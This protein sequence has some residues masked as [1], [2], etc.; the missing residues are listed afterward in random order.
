MP[1]VARTPASSSSERSASVLLIA[2]DRAERARLGHAPGVQDRL[3]ELLAVGLRQRLR[4]PPSRRTGSPAA[5]DVSRPVELVERAHPD[6]R[7][8]G[9]QRHLLV[10]D[11]LGD[12]RRGHLRAREGERAAGHHAR[13]RQAPGVGVEHR[14][15]RHHDVAL[16]HRDRVG[17]HRAERVQ[18]ASSGASRRRPSGGRSCRSCNTWRRPGSRPR[19]GTRPARRP[20]SAPRSRGSRSSSGTSPRAVVHH[21][22]V[23]DRA[24]AVDQRPQHLHAASGRR[25]STSSSAWS[26]M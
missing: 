3:A 15:D 7:D 9:R 13:V 11:Q 18:H 12:R 16:A 22:D 23:A 2:A 14:H 24:E 8:A 20:R 19:R 6:R 17:Q 21:D 10:L 4:A 1:W 5:Q 25:R 26:T